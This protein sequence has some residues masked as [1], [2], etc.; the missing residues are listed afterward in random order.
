M[1]LSPE[2]PS[3]APFWSEPVA[4]RRA[5]TTRLR[6]GFVKVFCRQPRILSKGGHVF[7]AK[8][9]SGPLPRTP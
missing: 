1:D 4:L 6:A 2:E 3:G 5:F 9:R 8:T 7:R